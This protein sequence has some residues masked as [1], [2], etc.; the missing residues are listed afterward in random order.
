LSDWPYAAPSAPPYPPVG[1]VYHAANELLDDLAPAL[2][3]D[4]LQAEC[5]LPTL[6]ESETRP[7]VTWLIGNLGHAR[8]H[9]GHAYL[10][11]QIRE[12]N[13]R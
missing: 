4:R 13:M 7:G 2:T 8:E 11:K 5:P 6:P 3:P 1:R 10:T 9:I 12:H